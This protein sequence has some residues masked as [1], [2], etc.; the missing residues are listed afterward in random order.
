MTELVLEVKDNTDLQVI[1]YILN[2]F[3]VTVKQKQ[4]VSSTN[5]EEKTSIISSNFTKENQKLVRLLSF[6]NERSKTVNK[7][8]IPS[9][10]ERNQR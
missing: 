3:G 10:D 1:L 7:I 4:V 5:Q 6:M 8:E 9:R 2:K